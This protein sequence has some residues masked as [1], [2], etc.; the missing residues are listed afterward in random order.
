M[1]DRT[2]TRTTL[3]L[4]VCLLLVVEL[5]VGAGRS[6]LRHHRRHLVEAD[7]SLCPDRCVCRPVGDIPCD[8]C[9]RTAAADSQDDRVS[10]EG[11]GYGTGQQVRCKQLQLYIINIH[12]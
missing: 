3:E 8:W 1:S 12:H 7:L 10:C 11:C 9:A 4:A 5:G 6:H 2:R